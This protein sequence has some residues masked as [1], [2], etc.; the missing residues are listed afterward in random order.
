MN[1][2]KESKNNIFNAIVRNPNSMGLFGII[3]MIITFA[4]VVQLSNSVF[5][6]REN[7]FNILKQVVT[8][9]LLAIAM[10]VPLIN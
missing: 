4:V 10:A 9:G 7:M 6:S 2:K 1:K 8:Y 3:C 5:L